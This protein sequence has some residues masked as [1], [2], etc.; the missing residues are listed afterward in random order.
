MFSIIIE[1]KNDFE[2]LKNFEQILEKFTEIIIN[3]ENFTQ[4]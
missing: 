4:I 3:H 2:N 1:N